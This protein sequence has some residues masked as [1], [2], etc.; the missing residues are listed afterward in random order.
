MPSGTLMI[1]SKLIDDAVRVLRS[2]PDDV[3]E[4]AARTIIDYG[5]GHDD[6]QLSDDRR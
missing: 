4:A 5:A 3:Q 2:L 6:I 1:M